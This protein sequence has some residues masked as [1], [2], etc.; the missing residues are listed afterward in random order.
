MSKQVVIV[1]LR[2]AG[3]S[4]NASDEPQGSSADRQQAQRI[5]LLRSRPDDWFHTVNEVAATT[6]LEW[7]PSARGHKHGGQDVA[8][9]PPLADRNQHAR[10][11][12]ARDRGQRL[13]AL[14]VTHP[15]AQGISR[16]HV[17]HQD[18]KTVA[19]GD[20]GEYR[21]CTAR[22]CTSDVSQ[23]WVRRARA[24]NDVHEQRHPR[25]RRP[26]HIGRL[27]RLPPP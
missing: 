11:T 7:P 24:V 21:A 8:R 16:P 26:H 23:N 3:W 19:R 6:A 5:H 13:D 2:P 1:A 27:L 10:D 14:R 12:A 25:K 17:R 18:E 4:S 22:S 20:A 15:A 9:R